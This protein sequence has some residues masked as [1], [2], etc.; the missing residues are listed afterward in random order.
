MASKISGENTYL[1][2]IA[3]LLGASS[4]EGFSISPFSLN[5]EF[6]KST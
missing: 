2:D 4:T 5:S 1:A 3:N 6:T